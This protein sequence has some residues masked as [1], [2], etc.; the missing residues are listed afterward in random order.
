MEILHHRNLAR[1]DLTGAER[2]A[3]AAEVGRLIAK[4]S[5]DCQGEEFANGSDGN[6]GNWVGEMAKATGTPTKTLYNW[7]KS[8]TTETGR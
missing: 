2:K 7:W 1:N 8:F 6:D 3:F 4:I 5:E